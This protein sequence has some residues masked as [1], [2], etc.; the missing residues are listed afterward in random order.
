VKSKVLTVMS[1]L[2]READCLARD[3]EMRSTQESNQNRELGEG[4]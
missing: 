3:G 2:W 4:R 1:L